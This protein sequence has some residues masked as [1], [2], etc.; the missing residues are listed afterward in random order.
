MSINDLFCVN[1]DAKLPAAGRPCP[2]CGFVNPVR[3]EPATAPAEDRPRVYIAVHDYGQLENL[4]HTQLASDHPVARFLKTELERAVVRPL[5]DLPGNAVR[6]NRRVLFRVD[7]FDRVESRFLVY[8]QQYHP[9]G[10]YL[11]VLSPL[12]VALL[13]LREGNDMPFVDLSGAAKRVTVEKVV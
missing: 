4:A 1:C 10:Q 6:M 9:S 13:G 11:S 8:P 5:H 3:R 2:A 12:G 7:D